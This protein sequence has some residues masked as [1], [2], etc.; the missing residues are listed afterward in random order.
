M[1]DFI[2]ILAPNSLHFLLPRGFSCSCSIALNICLLIAPLAAW[3]LRQLP[4]RHLQLLAQLLLNRALQ[5]LTTGHGDFTASPLPRLNLSADLINGLVDFAPWITRQP[6]TRRMLRL[7]LNA[8]PRMRVIALIQLLAQDFLGRGGEEGHARGHADHGVEIHPCPAPETVVPSQDAERRRREAECQLCGHVPDH[9]IP[10][11]PL[12][13]GLPV[14][15]EE[16]GPHVPAEILRRGLNECAEKEGEVVARV[17]AVPDCRRHERGHCGAETWLAAFR[18]HAQVD[19][20]AQPFVGVLVP[21]VEVGAGV[22]RH[23]DPEGGDVGEVVY[24]M[25]QQGGECW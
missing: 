8:L 15:R 21:V 10:D 16:E 6:Q 13:A 2:D 20:V 17:E 12:R 3:Y 19:V 5:A 24:F 25:C 22:L 7:L 14:A 23:F 1:L 18:G 11:L 4:R 9:V